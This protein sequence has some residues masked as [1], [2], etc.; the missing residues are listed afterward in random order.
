MPGNLTNIVENNGLR[1][2]QY[3]FVL[4]SLLVC[5]LLIY[6]NAFKAGWQYDDGVNIV[7]NPNVHLNKLSWSGIRKSFSG[8][9]P[10]GSIDRRPFSFFTFA[11]NHRLGKLNVFGYHLVNFGIHYC[12]AIFLFLFIYRSLQLPVHQGIYS[13]NAYPI[14]LLSMFF[15]ATHPIQVT[16]VTYLVQRMASM[17]ALFYILA[18]YAYL[19]GRLAPSLSHKTGWFLLCA[20][21]GLLS[22]ASKEN[23]AMLPVSLFLYD[24]IL[25]RTNRPNVPSRLIPGLMLLLAIIFITMVIWFN[26]DWLIKSYQGRSF[27]LQERLLT[28]PRVVLFYISLLLYPLS[29]RLSLIHDVELS[30]GLW[31]P[32]STLPALV[33]CLGL[34]GA[35]IWLHRK[36]PLLS[37]CLLFF[38]LNHLIE[39]SIFPLDLIYEHRNYLPSILFFLPLTLFF[40]KCLKYYQSSRAVKF[41]LKAGLAIWLA[42]QGHTV[43]MRNNLFLDETRLWQ[44]IA[45]KAPRLSIS[46]LNLGKCY[47]NNGLFQK[48]MEEYQ[49]AADLNR[50]LQKDQI[51]MLYY[52]MGLYYAYYLQNYPVALDY[53]KTALKTHTGYAPIW[54]EVGRTM[55]A[56]KQYTQAQKY[57]D[58][59]LLYWPDNPNLLS[60]LGAIMLQAGNHDKA[61]ELLEI[62]LRSDPQHGPALAILTEIRRAK[63][64]WLVP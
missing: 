12:A 2:R 11:L 31:Q 4:F 24:I 32:W 63:G 38:F 27:T 45:E 55:I 62:A 21:S 42:C 47:W 22:M 58:E 19:R 36:K 30:T 48:A 54:Y 8:I 34:A 44:D 15:W 29:S 9:N 52:N 10:D 64:L 6:H 61:L 20:F 35:P 14:A 5:L 56:L 51:S 3:A 26:L 7:D 23:A 40:F 17:A 49:M 43:Y 18:M 33:V 59:A 41:L 60:A 57:I 28:Q 39:S 25:L 37:Y 1:L 16:A 13:R 46:H 50:F 53:F